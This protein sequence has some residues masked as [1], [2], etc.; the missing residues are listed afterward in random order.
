MSNWEEKN[1]KVAFKKICALPF[2]QE[3]SSW[4]TK[5][6]DKIE[7]FQNNFMGI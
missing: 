3:I 2:S 1:Y 6:S 5:N 7:K 4:G